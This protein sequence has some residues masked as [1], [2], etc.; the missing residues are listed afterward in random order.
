MRKKITVTTVIFLLCAMLSGCGPSPMDIL[1]Q[2]IS[3][4][5][6]RESIRVNTLLLYYHEIPLNAKNY[7]KY[8][9]Y[10]PI[11][12]YRY[13]ADGNII[14]M[15]EGYE[16][17]PKEGLYFVS[18]GNSADDIT[19]QYSCNTTMHSYALYEDEWNT[20]DH[21]YDHQ[22]KIISSFYPTSYYE[23]FSEFIVMPRIE[24]YDEKGNAVPSLF[25]YEEM[26]DFTMEQVSGTFRYFDFPEDMPFESMVAKDGV[27]NSW[28]VIVRDGIKRYKF[29]VEG[30]MINSEYQDER[31]IYNYYFLKYDWKKR[32]FDEDNLISLSEFLQMYQ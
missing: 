23:T 13:G 7:K 17:L 26:T 1:S 20:S 24:T 18:T 25:P 2:V 12:K 29:V 14:A 10:G 5:N 22:S 16:F 27:G 28:Y 15:A 31:L 9:T 3:G 4:K 32:D 30:Y 11:T 6:Q 8:L 19:I 21:S